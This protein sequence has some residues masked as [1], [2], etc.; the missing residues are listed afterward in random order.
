MTITLRI[1]SRAASNFIDFAQSVLDGF[2]SVD[3]AGRSMTF[4]DDGSGRSI[5]LVGTGFQY[6][7]T[8]SP[9]QGTVTSA[10]LEGPGG[11]VAKFTGLSIALPNVNGFLQAG[12]FENFTNF[13][14]G[15][16]GEDLKFVGNQGRDV[17]VGSGGDDTFDGGPAGDTLDGGFA[18]FDLVTYRS[19]PSRV[20]A[21]LA[22]P[23]A[24]TGEAK[25][26]RYV[27]IEALE[28]GKGADRL[29][30]DA[31]GNALF[32]GDG[33][34]TIKG[35][36]GSDTITGGRGADLLDGQGGGDRFVFDRP[37]EAGDKVAT[38]DADDSV[39]IDTSAFG[40]DFRSWDFKS[41]VNPRAATEDATILYD[42][43]DR[44]LL[45]DLD[46]RAGDAP[47]LLF[48]ITGVGS[49]QESDIF[50]VA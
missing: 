48:T 49:V 9:T 40:L 44:K 22:A 5:V 10:T 37:S 42:T 8:G 32:G 27:S 7:S 3:R 43:T 14:R 23:E 45:I 26:D 24:N 47:L 6:G 31:F 17:L 39:Q 2:D 11:A 1:V 20:T 16:S 38:F 46:G 50:L 19:A 34:D 25:G 18:G 21:S 33:K 29:T 41:G 4:T 30:G 36:E 35:G 12:S 13:I 15:A 28:G